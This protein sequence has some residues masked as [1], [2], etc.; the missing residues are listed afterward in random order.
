LNDKKRRFYEI[1]RGTE[2]TNATITK[3]QNSDKESSITSPG[4]DAWL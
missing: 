2:G 1:M 4:T 3:G